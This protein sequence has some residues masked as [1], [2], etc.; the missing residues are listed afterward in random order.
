MQRR[1]RRAK[2]EGAAVASPLAGRWMSPLG[3]LFEIFLGVSGL[4][5]V[6]GVFLPV[7]ACDFRRFCAFLLGGLCAYLRASCSCFYSAAVAVTYILT[8]KFVTN[9]VTY[10]KDACLL[11]RAIIAI[12]SHFNA[13]CYRAS[14]AGCKLF[15]HFSATR[16]ICRINVLQ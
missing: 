11:L 10:D 5:L 12:F 9:F 14:G 8:N 1:D 3:E 15:S 2:T 6:L 4:S 16:C 7:C 13:L